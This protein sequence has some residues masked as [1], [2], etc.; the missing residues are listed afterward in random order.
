[1]RRATAC[2]LPVRRIKGLLI[3]HRGFNTSL[4]RRCKSSC[5]SNVMQIMM[6]NITSTHIKY[7]R[8]HQ[9]VLLWPTHLNGQEVL[10]AEVMAAPVK[11]QGL[12]MDGH[13]A[14]AG[15]VV[16]VRSQHVESRPHQANVRGVLGCMPTQQEHRLTLKCSTCCCCL[17]CSHMPR[18][19]PR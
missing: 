8:H 10:Q 7:A 3:G 12:R 13:Q 18:L 1:M 19:T 2:S 16:E 9:R 14:G 5:A 4:W 15:W 6:A 17:P 11:D